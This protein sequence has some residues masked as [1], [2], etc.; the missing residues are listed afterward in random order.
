MDYFSENN[1]YFNNQS[2]KSF[3]F[4]GN[5]SQIENASGCQYSMRRTLS[6]ISESS[7]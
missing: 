2:P 5:Y 4:N 1:P 7:Y 3:T 6:E